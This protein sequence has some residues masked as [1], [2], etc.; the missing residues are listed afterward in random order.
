MDAVAA[1]L[2]AQLTAIVKRVKECT[3]DEL[4]AL[5]ATDSLASVFAKRELQRRLEVKDVS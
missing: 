2:Q 1:A 4:H 3:L 5:V